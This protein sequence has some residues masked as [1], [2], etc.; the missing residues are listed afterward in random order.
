MALIEIV[1]PRYRRHGYVAGSRLPGVVVC[2]QCQLPR[3]VRQGQQAIRSRTA[4][5]LNADSIVPTEGDV[6][7]V[8]QVSARASGPGAI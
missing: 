1:C 5:R 3:L 8:A 2:S 4:A 7:T 6:Q